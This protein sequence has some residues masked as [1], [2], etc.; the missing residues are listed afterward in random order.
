MFVCYHALCSTCLHVF[1]LKQWS[2]LH[3]HGFWDNKLPCTCKYIDE[4]HPWAMGN[5][6][7]GFSNKKVSVLFFQC[8][9]VCLYLQTRGLRATSLIWETASHQYIIVES[10]HDYII[11]LIWR[12]EKQSIKW[13]LFVKLWVPFTKRSFS[14][15]L[16]ERTKRSNLN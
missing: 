15:D 14:S 10:Y 16:T 4:N 11:M 13:S 12:G 8:L 7:W 5:W 9:H 2:A 1:S 3:F 6:P